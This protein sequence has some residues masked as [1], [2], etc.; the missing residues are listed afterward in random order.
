GLGTL[1][2]NQFT[3][4]NPN[5]VPGDWSRAYDPATRFFV[6]RTTQI[7]AAGHVSSDGRVTLTQMPISVRGVQVRQFGINPRGQ[8]VVGGGVDG[9]R[10]VTVADDGSAIYFYLNAPGAAG[11]CGGYYSPLMVFFDDRRPVFSGK[12]RFPLNP[13]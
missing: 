4:V 13:L 10:R 7:G 2:V 9:Y 6:V 8:Y 12:S 11:F 5:P 1:G 3:F